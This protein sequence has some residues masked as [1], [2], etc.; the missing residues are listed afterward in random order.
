MHQSGGKGGRDDDWTV[1]FGALVVGFGGVHK[2]DEQS[3][4]D[5]V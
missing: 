2:G 5:T 1:S 4:R 3:E